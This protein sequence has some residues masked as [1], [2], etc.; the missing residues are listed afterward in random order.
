MDGFVWSEASEGDDKRN[1][2][3]H[4]VRVQKNYVVI[5]SSSGHYKV[6]D[7]DVIGVLFF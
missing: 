1:E 5:G 2:E 7:C 6:V 3:D 4:Y